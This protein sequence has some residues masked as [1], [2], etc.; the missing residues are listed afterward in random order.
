V[1][2]ERKKRVEKIILERYENN[3][4]TV[5]TDYYENGVL[6]RSEQYILYRNSGRETVMI[7]DQECQFSPQETALSFD[8][9][10]NSYKKAGFD[11]RTTEG[12]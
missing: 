3:V 8:E 7:R 6:V 9:A 4:Q 5:F 12:G 11:V 1:T 2:H 10:V